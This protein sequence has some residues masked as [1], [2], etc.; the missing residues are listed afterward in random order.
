MTDPTHNIPIS[1]G[2]NV[3]AYPSINI[4]KWCVSSLNFKASL[5]TAGASFFLL[6]RRDLR[7]DRFVASFDRGESADVSFENLTENILAARPE[8]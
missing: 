3:N 8:P 5:N 7:S 6:S 1:K 2:C 4:P